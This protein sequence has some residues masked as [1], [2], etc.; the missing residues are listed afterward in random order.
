MV[1]LI[2]IPSII[3]LKSNICRVFL[4]IF[5]FF[6]KLKNRE[7]AQSARDRKKQ[8][9]IDLER[10]IM[11]LESR[12]KE[13]AIEN[14]TLKNCTEVLLQENKRLKSQLNLSPSDPTIK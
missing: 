9:M 12:N 8:K 7:A 2:F 1:K 11:S 5:S 14:S 4:H 6:R 13:L 10:M 3:T